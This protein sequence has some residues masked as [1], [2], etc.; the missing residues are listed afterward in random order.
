MVSPGGVQA[1]RAER[2]YLSRVEIR[3]DRWRQKGT[4]G[5]F[6]VNSETMV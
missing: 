6:R 2:E 5:E 4:S 3:C 1:F